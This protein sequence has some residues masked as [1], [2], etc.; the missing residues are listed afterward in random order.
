M[1][2]P[3]RFHL[4]RRQ[5]VTGVAG[6][7]RIVEG[8]EFSDGRVALRWLTDTRSTAIYDSTDD[9]MAIHGHGGHTRIVWDDPAPAVTDPR[10]LGGSIVGPG[11]PH[12]RHGV[13]IDTDHAVLLNESHVAQVEVGRQ[14][15]VLAMQLSGR[16][17]KSSDRASVLFLLN[18]DGAAALIS[19]LV[20]LATRIGPEFAAALTARLAHLDEQGATGTDDTPKP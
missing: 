1:A 13:I 15:P 14:G 17:N 6:T 7:G 19:E 9:V 4:L 18:G 11:G 10:G 8:L 3:R 16:I 2:L 12:D 20:A 5:D